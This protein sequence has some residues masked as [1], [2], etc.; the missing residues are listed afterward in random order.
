MLVTILLEQRDRYD[1][2]VAYRFAIF[3]ALLHLTIDLLANLIE[4]Q[5]S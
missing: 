2:A 1:L 5:N 3:L 4:Q